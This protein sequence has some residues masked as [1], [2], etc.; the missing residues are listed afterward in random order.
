MNTDLPVHKLRGAGRQA[1]PLETLAMGQALCS[2]QG[3]PRKMKT[4][5]TECASDSIATSL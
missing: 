2:L 4:E 5:F 3:D 1:G